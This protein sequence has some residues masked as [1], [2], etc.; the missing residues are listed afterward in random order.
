MLGP[1]PNELR[2]KL[3]RIQTSV[4]KEIADENDADFIDLSGEVATEDGFLKDCYFNTDP[5]H[6]NSAYGAVAMNHI[7]E[8]LGYAL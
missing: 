3:Y 6:G 1:G 5:T 2:L 7:L 8:Q 4:F